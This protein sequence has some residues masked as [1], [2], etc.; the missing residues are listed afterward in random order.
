MRLLRTAAQGCFVDGF[1]VRSPGQSQAQLL[2]RF[3]CF[4][5]DLLELVTAGLAHQHGN[6]AV[7]GLAS[8]ILHEDGNRHVALFT[9]LTEPLQCF[10]GDSLDLKAAFLAM[11][12]AIHGLVPGRA[13]L[14]RQGVPVDLGEITALFIDVGGLQR[15]PAAFGAIVGQVGGDQMGMQ[16]RIELPAGVMRVRG[17]NQVAGG[18]VFIGSLEAH[19]GGGQAL[20]LGSHFPHRLVMGFGQARVD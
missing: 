13:H 4:G 7:G 20:H 3:D 6:L 16:L 10:F 9:P 8:V 1:Q 14:T 5:G 18:A 17:D 11:V 2:L 19:P 15:F 12:K